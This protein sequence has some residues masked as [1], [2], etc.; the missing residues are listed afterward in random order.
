M[1][2]FKRGNIWWY[3]FNFR[4]AR[5]RETTKT[6]NRD[7]AGRIERERRRDLELG[8]VGLR[9]DAGPITVS[10]AIEAFL[11]QNRP[12]WSERTYDLHNN[13]WTNHLKPHFGKLLL[14]DVTPRHISRYQSQRKAEEASPRTIN[15]ELGLVRMMLIKHRRWA[16]IAPDVHMLRER[17]DVGR[18]LTADEEYRLLSA[19]KASVSRGLYP[20]VVLSIHTG[21]RKSELRLMRWRQVD[22]LKEEV[23]VGKSKTQ[24]GDGRVIPLSATALQCVKEWRSQFPKA[25]PEHF[26]FPSEKYGLHGRKGVFGGTVKVYEC[27]PTKPIASWQS[28]W[29]TCKKAAKV[30]CRWHDLRHTFISRCGDNMVADQTL[31]AMTGQLSRKTLERYSHARMEAKRAAVRALDAKRVIDSCEPQNESNSGQNDSP[32]SSPQS[33]G[34]EMEVI[35]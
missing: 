6:R 29:V 18:S 23:Q 4:G 5:I 22:L 19:A 8:I 11:E 2:L 16:N 27:D 7:V 13:S 21:V 35:Q 26:V 15:L 33:Q 9:R 30:V 32:Q 10:K 34:G 24:G 31:M 20:A 1:S 3:E 14:E 17:E 12:R 25:R 28:A